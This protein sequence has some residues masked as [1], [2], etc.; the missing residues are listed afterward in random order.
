[1]PRSASAAALAVL[2]AKEEEEKEDEDGEGATKG[3]VQDLEEEETRKDAA[4]R[5][6]PLPSFPPSLL[7]RSNINLILDTVDSFVLI[8]LPP[9]LP[10]SL[11]SALPLGLHHR[12][13]GA[14]NRPAGRRHLHGLREGHGRH[15]R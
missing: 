6:G 1:M 2:Q 7:S 5:V 3:D 4:Q 10:P 13:R 9:S 12:P 14:K 11:P 15:R 8:S